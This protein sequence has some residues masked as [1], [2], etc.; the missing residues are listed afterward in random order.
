[1]YLLHQTNRPLKQFYWDMPV[2]TLNIS[3]ISTVV[4][5]TTFFLQI[6]YETVQEVATITIGSDIRVKQ[7]QLDKRTVQMQLWDTGAQER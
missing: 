3:L 1:M 7:I 5:K 2:T 6:I 4:G